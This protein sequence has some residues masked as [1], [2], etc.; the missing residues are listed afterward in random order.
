MA[1][2]DVHIRQLAGHDQVVEQGLQELAMAGILGAEVHRGMDS[3]DREVVGLLP[4]LAE[5]EH[6][7]GMPAPVEFAQLVG[8]VLHTDARA[9]I[10]VWW[11]FVRENAN[12][13]QS[14]SADRGAGA[15]DLACQAISLNKVTSLLVFSPACCVAQRV[16]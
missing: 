6:L 2:H 1:M 13:H 8:Q 4:L 9:A 7:D 10:D 11:I 14:S 3:L 5:A 15:R 16:I 12:L